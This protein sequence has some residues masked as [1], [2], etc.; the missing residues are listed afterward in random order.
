MSP[1]QLDNELTREPYVPLRLYLTNG[2]SVDILNPGLAF[3]DHYAL[4]VYCVDR[5]NSR[6]VDDHD[7]IS[8]HHI[9]RVEQ[10]ADGSAARS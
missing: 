4:H 2:E 1:E 3:I 5:P 6:L 9:V 7:L 8:L 10:I